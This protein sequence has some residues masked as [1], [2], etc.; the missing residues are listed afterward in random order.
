LQFKWLN[1]LRNILIFFDSFILIIILNPT[2][3]F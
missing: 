1:K 3:H 2:S